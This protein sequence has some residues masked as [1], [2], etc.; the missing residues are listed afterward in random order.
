MTLLLFLA[1]FDDAINASC[2]ITLYILIRNNSGNLLLTSFNHRFP[3]KDKIRTNLK[4]RKVWK[5]V[6]PDFVVIQIN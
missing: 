2:D 3:E 4:R 5:L 1:L 6:F